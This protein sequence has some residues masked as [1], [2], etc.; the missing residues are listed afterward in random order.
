MRSE[1][2]LNVLGNRLLHS[3]LKRKSSAKP[4][5]QRPPLYF[6]CDDLVHEGNSALLYKENTPEFTNSI[7]SFALNPI[8]SVGGRNPSES[9]LLHGSTVETNNLFGAETDRQ[10]HIND[11]E[12]YT[13]DTNESIRKILQNY[14]DT[15]VEPVV[16]SISKS[17]IVIGKNVYKFGKS[18]IETDGIVFIKKEDDIK[19]I[20]SDSIP[21]CIQI[22]AKTGIIVKGDVNVGSLR[23]N[24]ENIYVKGAITGETCEF[25]AQDEIDIVNSTKFKQLLI[26]ARIIFITD[27]YKAQET[28]IISQET[29]IDTEFDSAFTV[30]QADRL[31]ITGE[32]F[33]SENA[34]VKSKQLNIKKNMS[35]STDCSMILANNF[36]LGGNLKSVHFYIEA[37]KFNVT[38]DGKLEVKEN[39]II[40]FLLPNENAYDHNEPSIEMKAH[41]K[42]KH[43]KK[44]FTSLDSQQLNKKNVKIPKK[45]PPLKRNTEFTIEIDLEK[46]RNSSVGKNCGIISASTML[47]EINTLNSATEVSF[48]NAS[49]LSVSNSFLFDHGIFHNKCNTAIRSMYISGAAKYIG[50]NESSTKIGDYLFVDTDSSFE[51]QGEMKQYA[52]LFP[53]ILNSGLFV[54]TNHFKCQKFVSDGVVQ[55]LFN[56]ESNDLVSLSGKTELEGMNIKSVEFSIPPTSVIETKNARIDCRRFE[57]SFAE[58]NSTSKGI[59]IVNCTDYKKSSQHMRNWKKIKI[60]TDIPYNKSMDIPQPP[61]PDFTHSGFKTPL[62]KNCSL[63]D[64]DE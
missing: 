37:N 30:I 53:I 35:Y 62:S 42:P 2:F 38:K 48:I 52:F 5:A 34:V 33:I 63:E 57:I 7:S 16:I 39:L 28:I 41:A 49:A 1:E 22:L 58:F 4:K 25:I 13:L 6:K 54:T 50:F 64:L 23:I 14:N 60:N 55:G 59:L 8:S 29:K 51:N 32:S 40:L 44:S 45:V 56:V 15:F 24:A 9:K 61:K 36:Q 12:Q 27:C 26:R 19:L 47:L 43:D 18:P 46:T 11:I 20:L 31:D 10:S 21:K 17:Q 3:F